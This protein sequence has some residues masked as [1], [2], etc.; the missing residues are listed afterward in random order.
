LLEI[1][2]DGTTIHVVEL[3][4]ASGVTIQT[5][6][7]SSLAGSK[8]ETTDNGVR[9]TATATT[10]VVENGLNKEVHVA[11]EVSADKSGKA[12]HSM[13]FTNDAGE[14]IATIASSEL[15]G[16]STAIDNN[17][18][19]ETSIKFDKD[20]VIKDIN[21]IANIDGSAEH[22]MKFKSAIDGQSEDEVTTRATF[23]IVG[24]ETKIK[25]TGGV[26]TTVNDKVGEFTIKAVV[27][28]DTDGNSITKFE[29]YDSQGNLIETQ[30]TTQ[31]ATLFEPGNKVI[32]EKR[33]GKTVIDT[34][35]KVSGIIEF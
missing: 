5:S 31:S 16:A 13:S 33:D 6:A 24:A 23:N 19:I 30:K 28:T 20:N 17:G 21:V 35:A 18:K 29:K 10:H 34:T 22:V 1:K 7:T 11:I 26:E 12:T 9:T 8:T 4:T 3:K 14:S 2:P 32:I 25:T 27:E 15:V